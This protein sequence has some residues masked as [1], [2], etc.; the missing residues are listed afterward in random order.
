M[1]C[2]KRGYTTSDLNTNLPTIT[3]DNGFSK[4]KSFFKHDH[5][6]CK[7]TQ[8]NYLIINQIFAMRKFKTIAQKEKKK[9]IIYISSC[10]DWCVQFLRLKACSHVSFHPSLFSFF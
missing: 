9:K 3:K 10:F 2:G 5:F 4:L 8:I 1:P 7:L 6:A